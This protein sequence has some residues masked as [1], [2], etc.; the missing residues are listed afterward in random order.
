M[1]RAAGQLEHHNSEQDAGRSS[2][3]CAAASS[4]VCAEQEMIWIDW[5]SV[6]EC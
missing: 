4:S 2:Q 3:A 5:R 1:F 6:E